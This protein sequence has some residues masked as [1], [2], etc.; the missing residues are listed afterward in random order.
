MTGVCF[1]S[2]IGWEAE[3]GGGFY[4]EDFC[5]ASRIQD[6]VYDTDVVHWSAR[7]LSS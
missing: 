5:L 2:C 7:V 1:F 6:G 4:K 3:G